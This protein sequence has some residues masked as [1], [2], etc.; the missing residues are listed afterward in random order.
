MVN[1]IGCKYRPHVSN[2]PL[3]DD[4]KN[5]NSHHGQH[6]DAEYAGIYRGCSWVD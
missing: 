5:K 3:G 1:G 2:K 4:L 6:H